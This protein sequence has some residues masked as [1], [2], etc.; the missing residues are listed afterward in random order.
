MLRKILLS[1][2]AAGALTWVAQ[3]PTIFA[4][5]RPPGGENSLVFQ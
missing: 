4:D 5:F 1:T 3:F 2:L